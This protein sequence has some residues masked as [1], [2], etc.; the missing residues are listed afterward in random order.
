MSFYLSFSLT[1]KENSNRHY[2]TRL[3]YVKTELM[4][5]KWQF[6]ILGI[7]KNKFYSLI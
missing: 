4:F 6:V 2:D 7:R 1:G 3:Q 5:G